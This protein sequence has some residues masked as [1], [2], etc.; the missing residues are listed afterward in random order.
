M[1]ERIPVLSKEFEK[2]SLVWCLR[3]FIFRK[4]P[5]SLAN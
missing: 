1:K 4:L 5:F 3:S 2:V